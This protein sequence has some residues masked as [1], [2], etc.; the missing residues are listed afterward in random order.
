MALLFIAL[1]ASALIVKYSALSDWIAWW[2]F[3]TV[4]VAVAA[5]A[6]GHAYLGAAIG[7]K[8]ANNIL[9]IVL[10][11]VLIAGCWILTR[12]TPSTR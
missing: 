12:Y 9:V 6:F 11:A 7:G 2:A 4:P 1:A 5:F 8:R 3:G 10:L